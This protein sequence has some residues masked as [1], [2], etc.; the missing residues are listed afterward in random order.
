MLFH[1]NDRQSEPG[2]QLD[3]SLKQ[4]I[5]NTP[6]AMLAQDIKSD[7]LTFGKL[8]QLDSPKKLLENSMND[9]VDAGIAYLENKLYVPSLFAAT[10]Y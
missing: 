9:L 4:A 6:I 7:K 3:P 5:D 10:M 8:L 1:S 2:W